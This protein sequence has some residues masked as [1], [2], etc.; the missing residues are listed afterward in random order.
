MA[1]PTRL[2]QRLVTILRDEGA[3]TDPRWIDAFLRVPRHPFLPRFFLPEGD[4]W[5]AMS[6]EDHGWLKRVYSTNVL[7]TQLDDDQDRWEAARFDGP[8]PGT[9]TSSSSMPSIM[10]VM[11]EELQVSDGQTVL[12]I[13]TGTGYNAALLCQRVGDQNVSTVDIDPALVEPAKAALAECGFK[14]ACAVADGAQGFPSRAP[15]D[16]V[17]CTCAVSTIPLAWLEQ[18]VPGGLIVTT[19]NRPIGAG[20]L[21]IVAGKG[22]TGQGRVLGRD[23]RFMPLRADRLSSP[24]LLL[25]KHA[26]ESGSTSRTKL[27]LNAVLSTSSRFEFFA[28][29]EL[30]NV[31]A[32]G[33][34]LLHEDGSWTRHR[35]I[36]GEHF[37]EQGGPRRLWDDVERAHGEWIALGQPSR[38]RFGIT[39]TP[40]SQHFWLDTPRATHHWPLG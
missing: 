35:T 36:D 10:A 9:P 7:V 31:V 30:P 23:G 1:S 11:L 19:L 16:R 25:A 20:L 21:R 18:T 2:R 5:V 28:G 26:S 24:S 37:V 14:P 29:L 33:D 17:L 6:S 34:H 8:L 3:L 38:D 13:G 27:P 12:E 40:E 39:V 4:G 22:A 15:F 32:Y